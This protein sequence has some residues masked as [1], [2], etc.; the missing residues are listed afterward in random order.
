MQIELPKDTEQLAQDQAAAAGFASVD[1]Y[2]ADLI[3]HRKPAVKANRKVDPEVV[4]RR[5]KAFEE[6]RRLRAETPKFSREEIVEMVRE[7]RDER[8]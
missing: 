2:I 4:E 7:G 6:I 5:R 1:E 8:P 3:R